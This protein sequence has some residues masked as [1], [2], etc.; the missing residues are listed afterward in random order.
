M[1]AKSNREN[2]SDNS[3]AVSVA[4]CVCVPVCVCTCVAAL[5]MR[6]EN[7][8]NRAGAEKIERF[9]SSNRNRCSSPKIRISVESFN[10]SIN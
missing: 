7:M 9:S 4:M 10:Q 6:L 5:K 1:R 3:Y 8:R 2:N